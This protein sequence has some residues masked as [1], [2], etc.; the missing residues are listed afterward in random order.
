[1][2]KQ[3][4]RFPCFILPNF[5]EHSS[6]N[7]FCG[8]QAQLALLWQLTVPRGKGRGRSLPIA[9]YNI[10]ARVESWL[11]RNSFE[12]SSPGRACNIEMTAVFR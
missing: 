3:L 10:D 4:R 8:S 9:T 1:M 11:D 2:G 5:A 6:N 12:Y 7:R